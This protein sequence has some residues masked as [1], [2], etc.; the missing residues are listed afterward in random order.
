MKLYLRFWSHFLSR[1]SALILFGVLIIS[2]QACG[3]AATHVD[4]SIV[5]TPEST[6]AVVIGGVDTTKNPFHKGMFLNFARYNPETNRLIP[7]ASSFTLS[8]QP[9]QK[10]LTVKHIEPGHYIVTYINRILQSGGMSFEPILSP[11]ATRLHGVADN[12]RIGG[13]DAYRVK[14]NAGEVVYLGEYIIATYKPEWVNRQ[15]DLNEQM[16]KM[17]NISVTP[18][19]RPPTFSSE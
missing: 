5:L 8:D 19:F 12:A 17:K 1:L 10:G 15:Q 11:D 9:L 4:T 14:I 16:A 13:I 3:L 7:E 6:G 2:L 18:I